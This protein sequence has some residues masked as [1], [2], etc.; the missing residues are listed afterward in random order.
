MKTF[1]LAAL[2]GGA[3]G[4]GAMLSPAPRSAHG[5]TLD[6]ANKC[7]S[8]NPYSTAGLRK[9]EYC[10]NG[11]LGDAC[12]YYQVGCFAGCATC[13][14]TG[15]DL[16]PTAS[17]LAKAGNCKPIAPTLGGGDAAEEHR[18][19]TT[20]I[21]NLSVMGDWT[22]V[23]P[24][25]APG[26]AG[27]AAA[28]FEPCGVNSGG[29]ADGGL[30]PTTSHDVPTGGPGTALPDLGSQ[31]TW[32]AGA[33]VNT[34]WALYANHGGGYSYRICKKGAGKAA[35]TEACFQQT[36]LDFATAETTVVYTDGSRAPF[37]IK[38]PTTD[39][40]TH[41]AGSQWRKN[42]VPMC[43][44][45][46]GIGCGVKQQQQQEE[47]PVAAKAALPFYQKV[48]G[49]KDCVPDP[50]CSGTVK[51]SLPGCKKCDAALA[52]WSC[53]KDSCCPGYTEVAIDGGFYC[54]NKSPGAPTPS[55]KPNPMF[56]AYNATHFH[57]GQTSKIC[58]SGLQ[59]ESLWDEGVG[60]AGDPSGSFGRFN[61]YFVDQLQVPAAI[62]AGEYTLS[63]R[64]D[65][66]ET[67]QV[68]NSCAD[69]TITA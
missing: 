50:T 49:D 25:R 44:C 51:T 23:N 36:P 22:V 43:N 2:V 29:S 10:G 57:E 24:W 59:Y 8:S 53:A 14:L 27:L 56:N 13:S 41:P 11:C 52:A 31:A 61:Y 33:I 65:C 63:W 28:T 62:D 67:P 45:D 30:P 20:N 5:Q 48:G 12:L 64:W 9:G 19:R 17:D 47:K 32:A 3:S 55:P 26:S 68:W 42:P 38:V 6:A 54:T 7:G 58:P 66:E 16:Y 37:T 18:L 1:C 39:K 35:P 40:G 21:D 46:V 15:K 34:T 4:H 69:I 60:A